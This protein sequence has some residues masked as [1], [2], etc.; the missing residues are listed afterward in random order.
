MPETLHRLRLK[1]VLLCAP[2][3]FIVLPMPLLLRFIFTFFWG[4]VLLF[5]GA[6]LGIMAIITSLRIGSNERRA[7]IHHWVVTPAVTIAFVAL[8]PPLGFWS[9]HIFF[10]FLYDYWWSSQVLVTSFMSMLPLVL[11]PIVYRISRR[12][13]PRVEF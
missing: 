6:Y 9:M 8:Y 3:P 1:L 11:G 13:N 4:M 2:I 5:A 12:K 10:P 7:G